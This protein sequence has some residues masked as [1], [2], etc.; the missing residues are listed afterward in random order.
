MIH[1]HRKM[2]EI[3]KSEVQQKIGVT[4]KR[5][6]ECQILSDA[7]LVELGE[8]LNYNTIR[9]LFGVNKGSNV[10]PSRNTLD[11]LSRFLGY[12]TY[13]SFCKKVSNIGANEYQERWYLIIHQG[14]E[15]QILDYLKEKRRKDTNFTE[16]F[17]RTIRELFLFDR[18][19]IINTV[20]K[21]RALK[22]NEFS[23][24]ESVYM[25]NAIGILFRDLN[26]SDDDSL[27]LLKNTSFVKHVF[28]IFVDYGSLNKSYGKIVFLAQQQEKFL[29]RNDIQFFKCLNYFREYLLKNDV[30][31]QQNCDFL[32]FNAH[33]I[34]IGRM[35]A[36]ELLK[37][38]NLPN[39]KRHIFDKLK[40]RYQSEK[41]KRIDYFYE[42]NNVAIILS[43]FELMEWL[44]AVHSE[45][46]IQQYYHI[47][48]SQ[49]GLITAL[50]LSIYQ[51]DKEKQASLFMKIKPELW[52]TSYYEFF[53]LFYLIA[54]HH[55]SSKKKKVY[56]AEYLS[57]ASQMNYPLF[58]KEFLLT[59]FD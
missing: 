33:P 15:K 52:V 11:T 24:S 38:R 22:L 4:I 5:R 7:I 32:T 25:G 48:H 28:S 17:I 45:P 10:Q 19:D 50:L 23:Y 20:Y 31:F 13:Y 49:A 47:S 44:E 55:P 54:L 41:L 43:D 35:A 39:E 16:S 42:I 1:Q 34:L 57:R 27:L 36:M 53:N 56:E 6:G 3:L 18:I 51:K 58:D 30:T 14:S 40:E 26:L 29:S 9:R 2:I 37:H 12:N 46:H 21:S 59:Y 8:N